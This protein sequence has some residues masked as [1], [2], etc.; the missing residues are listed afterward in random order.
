MK[1]YLV[2]LLVGTLILS[3]AT[4]QADEKIDILID[5][6]KGGNAKSQALVGM[7]YYLGRGVPKDYVEALKWFRLA[8]D[9]GLVDSQLFLCPGN[10]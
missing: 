1:T 2:L 6:A 7:A 3:L 8:A 5:E 10:H 9:Q 4:A